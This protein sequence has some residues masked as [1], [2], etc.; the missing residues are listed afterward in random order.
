MGPPTI[1][2][3]REIAVDIVE[4]MYVGEMGAGQAESDCSEHAEAAAPA[5]RR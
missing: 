5:G 2:F 3:E 4:I 1:L